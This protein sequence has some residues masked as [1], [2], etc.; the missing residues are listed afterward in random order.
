M[1]APE[2][3]FDYLRQLVQ[4]Q[5]AVVLDAEKYYLAELHLGKI[6]ESSQFSSIAALVNLLKS[7]PIGILHRQVVEALVTNETSFFRDRYP[8]ETLKKSV[9]P[10][11]IQ[12][13]STERSL[14]IWCAACSYGQEPYSI[15]MLIREH[16][17]LLATWKIRLIASDFSGQALERARQGRYSQLEVSRGLPAPIREKYFEKQS[18][19]WQIRDDLKQMVEFRQINLI[20]PWEDLPPMDVIFLRNVLIY[21]ET[22]VKKAILK[23]VRQQ[24]RSD[25]YLF[26]GGGETTF[27]LDNTFE[28]VQIDQSLCHR[29]RSA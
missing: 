5:A 14:H 23:E 15:A 27:N 9:L 8:F 20:H 17:P 10:K 19:G 29:L 13:R 6:A 25:G 18:Q 3:D 2:F 26:L 22:D 11:L 28:S 21:F 12:N 4:K 24:L 16:F 7:S 1:N